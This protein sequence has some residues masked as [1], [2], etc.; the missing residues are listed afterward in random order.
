MVGSQTW[1]FGGISGEQLPWLGEQEQKAG[2]QELARGERSA[3]IEEEEERT[4]PAN[5][6]K[7]VCLN[8]DF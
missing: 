2:R 5:W 8:H 3:L 4:H 7:P 6:G 1:A